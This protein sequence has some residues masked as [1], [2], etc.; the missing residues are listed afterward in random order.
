MVEREIKKCNKSLC[1]V[2]DECNI[3]ILELYRPVDIA[4]TSWK[5]CNTNKYAAVTCLEKRIGKLFFTQERKRKEDTE[6]W[7]SNV[8]PNMAMTAAGLDY[9]PKI[10]CDIDMQ[11]AD[12]VNDDIHI[13][14]ASLGYLL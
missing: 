11:Q 1:D 14:P 6:E 4:V 13:F 9:F 10:V 12:K 8:P 5:I 7:C 2:L 3:K